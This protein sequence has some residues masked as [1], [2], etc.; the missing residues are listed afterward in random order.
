MNVLISFCQLK[1]RKGSKDDF[2]IPTPKFVFVFKSIEHISY[3]LSVPKITYNNI[4]VTFLLQMTIIHCL[5]LSVNIG[6]KTVFLVY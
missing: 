1:P 4:F 3:C 5:I 6:L 2:E